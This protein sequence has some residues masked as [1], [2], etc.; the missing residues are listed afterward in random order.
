M[1]SQCLGLAEA[2]GVVPIVK[3]VRLRRLWRACSPY[4]T[5]GKSFSIS[6]KGDEVRPPWPDLVIAS[7]RLSVVPSLH[8]RKLTRKKSFHVQIQ[9]PAAWHDAF[10]ALLVPAHD[11]LQGDNI[12]AMEGAL[13]RAT[14][15]LLTAE[16]QLLAPV[17]AHL[18]RPYVTVALGGSNASYRFEP[19]EMMELGS[20]LS[21]LAKEH[22]ASLLV[23]PSRRTGEANMVLLKA[24]L[25]DCPAFIWDGVGAN[26]Y[27][28]MLGLADYLIVTCDSVNMLSEACGTGKPVHMVR[29]PGHS[30]KFAD[31]HKSLLASDRV[32]LFNGRL[33]QW[34][35]TPL[36]EME[37]VAERVRA[38]YLAKKSA[39]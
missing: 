38:A 21:A 27:Y 20:Q 7:G 34:S 22:K 35:Y 15:E 24:L 29:L 11:H 10:D 3:R 23:T 28:G 30:D 19:R 37:R 6:S 36:R 1:E 13:H 16:A 4:L 31:F 5:L 25:H 14:P 17:V 8:I 18:P 39:L 32:R 2:L 26:P 33:E 12:I 9:N